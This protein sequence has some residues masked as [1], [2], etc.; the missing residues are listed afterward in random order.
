M[1]APATHRDGAF[2][3]P[4]SCDAPLGSEPGEDEASPAKLWNLPWTL[5]SS[6]Q[7]PPSLYFLP[8][9]TPHCLPPQPQVPPRQEDFQRTNISAPDAPDMLARPGQEAS[10]VE[11]LSFSAKEEPEWG[12][13]EARATCWKA[14]LCLRNLAGCPR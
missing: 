12:R 6:P 9:E 13:E 11:S 10:G 3:H 14:G 8:S 2:P 1:E 7:A 5:L 4:P